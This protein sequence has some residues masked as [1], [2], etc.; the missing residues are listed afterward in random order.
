MAIVEQKNATQGTEGHGRSGQQLEA[1]RIMS[2]TRAMTT[3]IA[4][5]SPDCEICTKSQMPIYICISGGRVTRGGPGKAG[6]VR[7]FLNLE[8][9]IR[10]FPQKLSNV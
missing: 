2:Y 5:R 4:E 8:T 3:S 9:C 7:L 1:T 10:A 6:H